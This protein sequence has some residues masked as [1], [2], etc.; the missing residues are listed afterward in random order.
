[1]EEQQQPHQANADSSVSPPPTPAQPSALNRRSLLQIAATSVLGVGLARPA[2][3]AETPPTLPAQGVAL[4]PG[5]SPNQPIHRKVSNIDDYLFRLPNGDVIGDHILLCPQK[6][7]GGTHALDLKTGTVMASIWYWNYGDYCPISHHI[8]AFPS[9]NPYEGFEFINS[10]QGGMDALIFGIPTPMT[11]P[12]EGFNMYKVKYDGNMMVLEDNVAASTGLGLGV[13]T[14]IKPDDAQSYWITDGQKDIA[15][16]FDR[17]SSQVKVALKY[18][19]VPNVPELSQAWRQG[20][21]LKVRRI[22]PDATTGLFDYQGTKGLKIDWEMVPSGEL[23]VEEGQIPGQD[24]LGLCGA[25]G[26]IWHPSGRWAATLIRL[27]GGLVVLDA[28]KNMEPVTFCSFNSQTPDHYPVTKTDKDT[29]EIKLDQVGSPGH[30]SGFSPDG[31]YFCFMNNGRENA[32]GV[33]DSSD[34]DPKK[35][36]KFAE[37]RD[38]LW[39]GRYPEPFHMVFTPDAKKLYLVIL[40]PAPAKSG[41]MVIDTETWKIRKEIQNIAPDVE[42]ITITPDGRYVVG[43]TGGFQRYRSMVY[44]IDT[45]TDELVGFMPSPGGHHDLSLVPRSVDELRWSRSC[46]L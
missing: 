21:T 4:E 27:C 22:Y 5:Y 12:A 40:Y 18:D 45:R 7:G 15:A 16:W 39:Y 24:V 37:I 43:I 31:K 20:G 35:W 32:L 33:F 44:F 42:S 23:L 13:H 38:P 8:Q 29:W 41:V 30:E 1:M 19:W 10:C 17:G 9:S 36:K 11:E 28:Q 26:T 3:A 25:D 6:M 2:L 34:P 46:M 14:T